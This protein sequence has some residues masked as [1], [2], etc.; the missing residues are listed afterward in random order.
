M[1]IVGVAKSGETRPEN[2]FVAAGAEWDSRGVRG[3]STSSASLIDRT[4]SPLHIG[5]VLLFVTS[6]GVLLQLVSWICSTAQFERRNLHAVGM[7]IVSTGQTHHLAD[8]IF[9]LLQANSAFNLPAFV[10]SRSW[11]G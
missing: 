11:R 6:Q 4:T 1:A 7:E 2:V 5:H 10:S 8:T 3:A 9:V